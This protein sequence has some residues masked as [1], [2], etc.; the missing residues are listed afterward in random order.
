MSFH[1]L[2]VGASGMQAALVRQSISANNVANLQTTAFK[3]TLARQTDVKGGGTRVASTPLDDR[4]GPI[5]MATNAFDL[6]ID[7]PGLLRVRTPEGIRYTRAGVFGLDAQGEL[8]TPQGY[9]LDPPVRMAAGAVSFEV[10]TDGT[11]RALDAN[12]NA[13]VA[14]QIALVNFDNV[15]GLTIEG[16]NLYAASLASGLPRGG[17]PGSPGFGRLRTG[18]LE[19]SN[20]DLAEETVAQIRDLHAFKINART[21]RTADQMLG[22]LLDLRR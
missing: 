19:G 8:V 17:A 12:G 7:G 3:A 22:T 18:A 15:Q 5:E 10:A 13:A 9:H 4:Q 11:V 16:R 20:V 6:A 14:G 2:R 1:A 21:V